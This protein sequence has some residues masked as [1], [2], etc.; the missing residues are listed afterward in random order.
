MFAQLIA[1]AGPWLLVPQPL[2]PPE[3]LALPVLL[4]HVVV[5]PPNVRGWRGLPWPEQETGYGIDTYGYL[6]PRIVI[7]PGGDGYYPLT[8]QPYRFLPTRQMR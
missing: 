4:P 3:R 2:P 6:R 5:Q 8:G 7:V 1:L